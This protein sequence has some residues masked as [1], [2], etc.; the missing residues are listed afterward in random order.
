[1]GMSGSIDFGFDAESPKAKARWFQSL[2]VADLIEYLISMTNL[3]LSQNPDLP[4]IKHDR[5]PRPGV[6]V[7]TLER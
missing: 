4:R 1:M 6:R 5:P 3:A 2:P 7:L